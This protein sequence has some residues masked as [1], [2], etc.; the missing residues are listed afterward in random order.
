MIR[1]SG[2]RAGVPGVDGQKLAQIKTTAAAVKI[3]IIYNRNR[4]V[5]RRRR[6]RRIVHI[7]MRARLCENVWRLRV[8]VVAVGGPFGAR[9]IF[10]PGAKKKVPG[11]YTHIYY[12]KR[13]LSRP[14]AGSVSLS[15]SPSSRARPRQAKRTAPATD[16]SSPPRRPVT[17]IRHPPPYYAYVCVLYARPYPTHRRRR[18]WENNFMPS[19]RK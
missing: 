1:R 18:V 12:T 15:L 6:R 3:K 8:R 10:G 9:Q 4:F 17:V 16:R 14:A 11:M 5:R 7:K 13:G 2:G 19:I